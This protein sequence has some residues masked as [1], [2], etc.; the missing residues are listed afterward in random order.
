MAAGPIDPLHGDAPRRV[1]LLG[2]LAAAALR[3]RAAVRRVV[4]SGDRRVVYLVLLAMLSLTL[5]SVSLAQWREIATKEPHVIPIVCAT[6]ACVAGVGILIFYL[7]AW[8][9]RIV[10]GLLE[11]RGTTSDT[12]VALAWGLA[13]TI[14]AIAYR[15]PAILV[16]PSVGVTRLSNGGHVSFS[17]EALPHGWGLLLLI[18]DWVVA[19]W[20]VIA[21]SCTLAGVHRFSAL[22]GAVTLGGATIAPAIVVVGA[23]IAT[24]AS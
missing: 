24:S 12:R 11:G 15:L 9:G 18:A 22:R 6:L 23:A 1:P 2:G 10:A 21:T 20:T 13:P 17:F 14:L 16:R 5:R 3:P 8:I 19:A 4:A 7:V